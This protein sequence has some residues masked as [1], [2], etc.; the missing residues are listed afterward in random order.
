[1]KRVKNK[2]NAFYFSAIL[3]S[4]IITPIIGHYSQINSKNLGNQNNV[5]GLIDK[6][7]IALIKDNLNN[8]H[9]DMFI[10]EISPKTATLDSNNFDNWWL[11]AIGATNLAYDGNGVTVAILD[12]GI[13]PSTDYNV[14]DNI[15]FL[16]GATGTT[17][18]GDEYG[19]GTHVAGIVGGNGGGSTGK[20]R[21]VAPGVS[22]IN[23]KIANQTG[24]ISQ[25]DVVNAIQWCKSQDVDIISMSFGYSYPNVYDDITQALSDATDQGII[26]VASAG[27]SGPEYFTGG[28]PAVGIDVISV[29]ATDKNDELASFS[30]IGPTT[31]DFAFPDVVAPGVDIIS[32]EA[33]E[34]LLSEIMRYIGDVFDY[35]G[36]ADY[37]PLSGTSMSCPMVAGALAILL[38]AYPYLTPETA[39]IAL[40]EGATRLKDDNDAYY[41]KSGAGLINVSASLKFLESISGDINNT[42]KILPEFLPI[43]PYDLLHFPGDHQKFNLTILS[44]KDNTYA[45]ELPIISGVTL[46]LEHYNIYFN[47]AG[48]N[49]TTLDIMIDLNATPGLRSFSINLINNGYLNDS[50]DLTLDIR[51]PEHRILMESYHGLND[52]FPEFSF[53]QMGFYEAMNVITELNISIDYLMEY[54]TPDYNKSTDNSILTEERLSQ[55][56]LVV[57]QNPILPYSPL[58]MNNLIDYFNNGGNILFLGTLYQ[59]LCIENI[60]DLFSR[61]G[62]G[63]EINE[64]NIRIENWL[65]LG[66]SVTGQNAVVNAA[67][68]IF[69]SV[70]TFYWYYGSSISCSD[71]ANSIASINGKTVT[72]AYNGSDVGKGKVVAFGDLHWMYDKFTLSTNVQDHTRLLKNIMEYYFPEDTVPYSININIPSEAVSNPILNISIY[73]K[74]QTSESPIQSSLLTSSNLNV[75]LDNGSKVIPIIMNSFSNGVAF[76]DTIDLSAYFDTSSILFTIKVNFTVG[77]ITYNKTVK[78]LYFDQSDMPEINSFKTSVNELNKG[79]YINLN[80]TLSHTNCDVDGFMSI[81]TYS[82]YNRKQTIN[83]TLSFENNTLKYSNRTQI[84]NSDPSGYGIVYLIANSSN[85][86]INSR[87]PRIVF[88]ILNYYPKIINSTSTCNGNSIISYQDEEGNFIDY[89][90]STQGSSVS[91]NIFTSDIEDNSENIRVSVNLVICFIDNGFI[92]PIEPS[93]YEV[94][95][96]SYSNGQH[97]GSFIIPTTMEYNSI[98]GTKM[99]STVATYYDGYIGLF[100][101]TIFDSEGGTDDFYLLVAINPEVSNLLP[102]IIFIVIFSVIGGIIIFLFIRSRMASRH[103]IQSRYDQDY[104]RPSPDEEY[105]TE[106]DYYSE[107][108]SSQEQGAFQGSGYFCPVCGK[109]VDVPKKFCPHCGQSVTFE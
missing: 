1:M 36:S 73:V 77:S 17:N 54:W 76:N 95:E 12:T 92:I 49:F 33:H 18:T 3:I 103:V 15:W 21:G 35:T 106:S 29:G 11:E 20:Y 87:S 78:F 41:L 24:G 40:M 2:K 55:Y 5:I 44:G 67:H 30:S 31:L 27:N 72:A 98:E 50:I 56:D 82:Y 6:N 107:R 94:M 8:T 59:H 64:E 69:N 62:T 66:A 88:K 34:S 109:H 89:I 22:L 26:C 61:L 25:E 81:Y 83:R 91:F 23:V 86:Y 45:L 75:V 79:N 71:S 85:N 16:D 70:N 104:H 39:R 57:L 100:I 32:V 90:S 51:L 48:V 10:P 52:F 74:N 9:S 97:S 37:I 58:E 53:Y 19:H 80:S 4:I 96:L 101:L 13:F 38:E 105:E 28:S 7:S 93:S 68:P 42:G 102:L 65:G 60:N 47:E 14:I 63:I 84:L 43:K 108:I 46:S 99:I